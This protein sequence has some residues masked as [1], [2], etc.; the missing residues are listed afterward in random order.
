MKKENKR[1]EPETKKIGYS[2]T[3]GRNRMKNGDMVGEPEGLTV[4]KQT[5]FF[6]DVTQNYSY[7]S[8]S[9]TQRI[10]I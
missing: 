6:I 2:E 9:H 4:L 10:G 3:V 5:K 7:G 1:H 8:I